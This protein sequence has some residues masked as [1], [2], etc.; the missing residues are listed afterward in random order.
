MLFK[1]RS[2]TLS[3]SNYTTPRPSLWGVY[4]HVTAFLTHSLPSL[5]F[6]VSPLAPC[7]SYHFSVS[8]CLLH[9]LFVLVSLPPCLSSLPQVTT[10]AG[11]FHWNIFLERLGFSCR[12]AGL[13]RSWSN[14]RLGMGA[15]REWGVGVRESINMC[16]E[17]QASMVEKMSQRELFFHWRP[18]K[19]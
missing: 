15:G 14:V 9:H 1:E 18:T 7:F 2:F 4:V 6:N 5:A 12:E 10:S 11:C 16:Q 13:L 19:Q 17:T 8:P 3:A